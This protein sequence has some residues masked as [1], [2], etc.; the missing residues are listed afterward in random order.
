MTLHL[1]SV[2]HCGEVPEL[3]VRCKEVI[4]VFLAEWEFNGLLLSTLVSLSLLGLKNT[5]FLRCGK[6]WGCTLPNNHKSPLGFPCAGN[7]SWLAHGFTSSET[8][9]HPIGFL[10]SRFLVTFSTLF[11]ISS[12]VFQCVQTPLCLCTCPERNVLRLLWELVWEPRCWSLLLVEHWV[13]QGKAI[14]WGCAWCG[15]RFPNP[16]GTFSFF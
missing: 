3:Q 10:P 8:R 12:W 5:P 15:F 9:T 13:S 1:S 14:T 7:H 4:G 11:P 16:R 6:E 2:L